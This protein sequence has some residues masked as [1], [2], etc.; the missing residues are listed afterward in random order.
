M[1]NNYLRPANKPEQ[2]KPTINPTLNN[3]LH[4]TSTMPGY[5]TDR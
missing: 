1:I 5:S 2:I 4:I 3:S